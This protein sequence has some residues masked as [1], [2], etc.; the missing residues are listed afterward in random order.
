MEKTSYYLGIDLDN[1]NAVISYFQLNM[2]E[3]E[4]VST[5]AGSKVYQIPLILA[6]KHGIGQWFIGE[7]AKRLALLQGE[8][9]VSGLLQ[10]ALAG[11]EFFI[12]GETYKAQELLAL[13]IKKLVYLAGKLGN[14]VIPDFLVITL[15]QLSREV[16]ELFLQVAERIGIPE[17][18]LTLIDRRE[19][20]YYFAFSQQK[21]LWLHDVCLFDNRGDEVWCRRLERDQR[22]MPQLVTISEEQRNI[23]RANKDA[24][25]LKIVSEVTGGH[26]VS[27]VYLTGDGFD[28]EWMKESLSFLCKGRRVFM[29]KNLYS[30]GACYAAARKCMTEE[31]SWQFVYMGDN[32]MKVN[33]SLKVQSQGKTEF[34]TLISAGDNWYETVGECEVLLDGSNEIDFWLQLPNSKEAKI[35]KLTLADLPERPPRT[36]RLRIKAQPVSDMEV[37]IRIKDLGFGEIFKSSDKTWE[38]MMSLENVQ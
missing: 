14:P 29:G 23:D 22:T 37:K 33:V 3:P 25:F 36:T 7:E 16:T 13:Y 2:K 21:E 32:E 34:F 15:E 28:G 4:T 5:V 19:S 8:E 9:A 20:F 12:E 18:K 38:Y 6:K 24:S 27:A 10:A 11:K 35:E 17:G 26:I 1:D 30:K 31:N